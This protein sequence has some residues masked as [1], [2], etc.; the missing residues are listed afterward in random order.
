MKSQKGEGEAGNG[1]ALSILYEQL[2]HAYRAQENFPA[3][4]R[5]FQEMGK[6][7]P[8]AQRRAQML[9]IDTYR[10]SRDLDRAVAEAKKAL[11]ASPKDQNLIVTL[12]MLY[13]EKSDADAGTKLLN[14]LLQGTDSDQGIYVDIAQVQERGRKYGDAEQSAQKAEELARDN[15]DKE[16]AWFM[17]GAIYERQKKF[18]QAEQEFRKVLDVNP[19]NAPVLNYYGYM[20]ADR[21]LRLDE[22]TSMIQRAVTQ[23][24]N[25]GAYLDSLGWAYYK[26]NK[27]AEAEEYLRK[28]AERQSH[29]PTILGHLGDVYNKL[30]QKDR[31]VNYW[32][33]ALSEWQKSVP[34]DYEAEK[35]NDLDA[36]LRNSK[37]HTA[38]KSSP[39]AAKPQ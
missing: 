37:H 5:T 19:N 20:L 4:I 3:A 36:Q 26:Q 14:G 23:E 38:Q 32:E 34:A 22:A 16:T 10:E 30:G 6:L 15:S 21:G 28:A 17:L 1:S 12:A 2:G 29:D 35:V 13:G 8:D 27:L 25:N 39:E 7:G 18:D 11:E 33:R 9:L 31:A 24:P